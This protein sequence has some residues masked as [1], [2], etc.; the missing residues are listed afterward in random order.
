MDRKD[1]GDELGWNNEILERVKQSV[2]SCVK[3][4]VSVR[5]GEKES[6]E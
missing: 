4:S 5:V 2:D 3:K 1:R 6:K